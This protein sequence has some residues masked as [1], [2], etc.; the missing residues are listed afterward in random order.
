[1]VTTPEP[2]RAVGGSEQRSD[3]VGVEVCDGRSRVSFGGDVD[4]PRDR[5]SMFGVSQGGVAE[6][7]VD[8]CEPCVAGAE[9]VAAVYF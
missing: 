2:H 4:H 3:L 8:G 5:L 6:Q 9:A 1:M 7:R